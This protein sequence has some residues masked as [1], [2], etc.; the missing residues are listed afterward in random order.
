M[1][2][3]PQS[4]HHRSYRHS[5]SFRSGRLQ[6]AMRTI[7][8]LIV[9]CSATPQGVALGFEDCRRD[10]IHHPYP[11]LPAQH[12]S[13]KPRQCR[14][15]CAGRQHGRRIHT[16]LF[17]AESRR[18]GHQIGNRLHLAQ[19]Y[20]ET[21]AGGKCGWQGKLPETQSLTFTSLHARVCV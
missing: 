5:G 7:T 16:G 2:H 8:L 19:T 3:C 6:I 21:R 14:P 20:A 15:G 11:L 13:D 12:R 10:H 18:D 1:G 17:P 9:H 4:N